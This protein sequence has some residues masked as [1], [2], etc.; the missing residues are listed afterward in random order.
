MAI[1]GQHA[2]TLVFKN[3]GLPSLNKLFTIF[4]FMAC[5]AGINQIRLF[6]KLIKVAVHHPSYGKTKN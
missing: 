4:F 5:A 2:G 1:N 6:Q 3:S